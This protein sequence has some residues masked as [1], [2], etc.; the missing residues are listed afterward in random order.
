MTVRISVPGDADRVYADEIIVAGND[1]QPKA[2]L[3]PRFVAALMGV[4]WDWLT[5][6]TSEATD[7]SPKP[8]PERSANCSTGSEADQ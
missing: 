1:G 3:N 2:D 4:P 8:P 7:S 5:H 6:S